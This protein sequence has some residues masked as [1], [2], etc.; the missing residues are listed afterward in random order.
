[1]AAA[2]SVIRTRRHSSDGTEYIFDW[3]ADASGDVAEGGTTGKGA[4]TAHGFLHSMIFEPGSG[5]SDLYDLTLLD[6]GAGASA[7]IDVLRGQGLNQKSA[8]NNTYDTKYRSNFL[9]VDGNYMWFD[10][11]KLVLTIA[12]GGN[13]GSGRIRIKFSRTITDEV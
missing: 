12:N 1:M 6:D 9:N 3:T 8:A 2:G 7:A 4:F 10:N 13:L 5:A 11:Q